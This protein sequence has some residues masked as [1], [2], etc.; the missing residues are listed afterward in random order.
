MLGKRGLLNLVLLAGVAA[1]AAVAW[2]EPGRQPPPAAPRLIEIPNEQ[3][4]RIT[5]VRGGETI[6]LEQ[7]QDIWWLRKPYVLRANPQQVQELL[8]A[9]HAETQ[10][11]YA[12]DD[13][14]LK[15]LGF[16]DPPLVITL[17]DSL[18]LTFGDTAPLNYQR[19]V[20]RGDQVLL[21]RA[22]DYFPLNRAPVEFVS[23]A[24]LPPEANITALALPDQRLEKSAAGWQL[25]PA[26]PAISADAIQN[27]LDAWRQVQAIDV[28]PLAKDAKAQGEVV[29]TLADE[30]TPVRFQILASDANLLLGRPD[31]SLQYSLPKGAAADLLQLVPIYPELGD[32][33]SITGNREKNN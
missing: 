23:L 10:A 16:S 7:R 18:A 26:N 31:L 29:I 32:Q 30:E 5:I 17:N 25:I 13:A 4:H 14:D 1:L 12:A 15:Q 9:L 3:I 21:L 8:T 2:F 24:L 33:A 20:H 28:A 11:N 27:L 19:Y 22:A 6:A